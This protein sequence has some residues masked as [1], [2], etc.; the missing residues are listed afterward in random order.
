ML[1]SRQPIS[2]R[3]F[4]SARCA[5]VPRAVEPERCTALVAALDSGGWVPDTA[6]GRNFIFD[7][8]SDPTPTTEL[9]EDLAWLLELVR[10][11]TVGPIGLELEAKRIRS[12][13]RFPWHQ[14]HRA[15]QQL[16]LRLVLRAPKAGGAFEQ[17]LKMYPGAAQRVPSRVGDL[18]LFDVTDPKLVHRVA[19]LE[20]ERVAL[21]GWVLPRHTPTNVSAL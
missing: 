20:G 9:I 10:N 14:D 19:P 1:E 13:G 17:R 7:V 8:P 5:V 18:H 2:A 11:I 16:G 3:D 21:A 4:A 15:G 6:T 12:A